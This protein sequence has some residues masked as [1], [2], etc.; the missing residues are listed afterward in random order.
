MSVKFVLTVYILC[1]SLLSLLVNDVSC[2]D[3]KELFEELSGREIPLRE[4]IANALGETI[5][6]SA[7][8]S[9]DNLI[10][11]NLNGYFNTLTWMITS[12]DLNKLPSFNST[13]LASVAIAGH[14]VI[15]LTGKCI[16]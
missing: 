16:S 10:T 8:K 5:G 9:W 1:T 12:Q 2:E 7:R 14:F 6:S 4:R 13:K 11:A 15:I 3:S